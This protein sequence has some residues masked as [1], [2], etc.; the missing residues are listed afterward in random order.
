M[1]SFH[2]NGPNHLEIHG[3]IFGFDKREKLENFVEKHKHDITKLTL[4]SCMIDEDEP[5]YFDNFLKNLSNLTE[6]EISGDITFDVDGEVL[7][8]DQL[9]SLK[10]KML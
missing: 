7:L 6:L 2:L 10:L 8:F 4:D 3:L 9:K 1:S 5:E